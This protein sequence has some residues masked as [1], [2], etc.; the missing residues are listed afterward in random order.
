MSQHRNPLQSRSDNLSQLTIPLP[1]RFARQLQLPRASSL[2]VLL[3]RRTIFRLRC[4]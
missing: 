3:A 4:N 1:Q 2:G